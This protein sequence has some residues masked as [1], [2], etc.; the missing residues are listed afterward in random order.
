M[1]TVHNIGRPPGQ[2][3]VHTGQHRAPSSAEGVC[4]LAE[5]IKIL[6]LPPTA[7]TLFGPNSQRGPF[8]ASMLAVAKVS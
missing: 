6:G 2:D 4:V 5:S 1:P 3:F 7:L 8:A